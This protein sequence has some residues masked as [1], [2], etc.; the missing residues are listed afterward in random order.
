MQKSSFQMDWTVDALTSDFAG[1]ASLSTL[2]KE[3]QRIAQAHCEAVGFGKAYMESIHRVFLLTKIRA[4]I[5]RSP[6]ILERVSIRTTAYT[7][8][9]ILFPRRTEFFS[10]TGEKLAE[11]FSIW[12]LVD[13]E[14][15]RIVRNWDELHAFPFSDTP[16]L[17]RIIPTPIGEVQPAE[18]VRTR[19]SMIDQNHHVNNAVY[20]DLILDALEEHWFSGALP[21]GFDIVYHREA[22]PGAVIELSTS[23]AE[24]RAYVRGDVDGKCCF[25]SE[26]TWS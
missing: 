17:P 21:T 19:Y 12:V 7:P 13:T 10:E 8:D 22:R 11:L 5:T 18:S 16:E 26:V 3:A 14:T 25:E 20:A 2:L 23:R 9:R 1:R 4:Q 6:G 15:L 24:G